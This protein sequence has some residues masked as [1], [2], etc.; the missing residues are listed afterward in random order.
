M[1][2]NLKEQASHGRFQVLELALTSPFYNTSYD[3]NFNL[4]INFLF[5]F[6]LYS[7]AHCYCIIA[8]ASFAFNSLLFEYLDL[9][10]TPLQQR[11]SFSCLIPLFFICSSSLCLCLFISFSLLLLFLVPI[12]NYGLAISNV[13]EERSGG[14]WSG[15]WG[16]VGEE[17]STVRLGIT[18]GGGNV[19]I[20]P[21]V[22]EEV[23]SL[24][25]I[26]E[27]NNDEI[28]ALLKD[29]NMDLIEITQRLFNQGVITF[30]YFFE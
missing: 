8:I 19:K 3:L 1:A 25:E 16:V 20:F 9:A 28:Y 7:S 4:G 23:W 10:I 21:S 15:L 30:T 13:E 6:Y 17:M 18:R 27:N 11:V 26:V 29:C 14:R 24:K 5:I 2:L 12:F 22:M